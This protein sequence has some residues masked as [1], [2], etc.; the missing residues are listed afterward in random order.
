MRRF[1]SYACFA[2]F[3]KLGIL[4][5]IPVGGSADLPGEFYLTLPSR[6]NYKMVW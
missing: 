3:A 6:Q 2:F 4:Q 1:R 5:R